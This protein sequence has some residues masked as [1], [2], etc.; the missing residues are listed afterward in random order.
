MASPGLL[1][2]GDDIAPIPGTTR[3]AH[4]ED[5][6]AADGIELTTAQIEK[7]GSLTPASGERLDEAAMGLSNRRFD[8][9]P[10]A[11]RPARR[12]GGGDGAASCCCLLF[13]AESVVPC[14]SG[15]SG[16]ELPVEVPGDLGTAHRAPHT[17]HR[18][19][20]TAH[21]TPHTAHRG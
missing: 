15:P 11:Y 21:R 16:E 12:H 19:P 20:H 4:L 17:A 5:N 8:R 2:Q 9:S 1:A 10:A 6:T 3:M 7:P 14:D 18:T 13:V